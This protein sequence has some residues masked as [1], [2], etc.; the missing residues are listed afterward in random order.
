MIM[1]SWDVVIIKVLLRQDQI[2]RRDLRGR[3][4]GRVTDPAAFE[5]K[6]AKSG[7]VRLTVRI[8]SV[9]RI[10]ERAGIAVRDGEFVK[11]V[12]Y[13]G[14]QHVFDSG[15]MPWDRIDERKE[16]AGDVE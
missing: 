3:V 13:P 2:T 8:R 7:N 15:E 14:L 9:L 16:A 11:I 6:T 1:K 10:L 4:H 5:R 12:D